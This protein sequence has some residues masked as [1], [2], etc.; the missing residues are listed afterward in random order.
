MV[1]STAFK[2]SVR[3]PRTWEKGKAVVSKE[4]VKKFVHQHEECFSVP[5]LNN[6]CTDPIL[7]NTILQ[8]SEQVLS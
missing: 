2:K 7:R 6:V 8:K 1:V 5:N 4:D 3:K